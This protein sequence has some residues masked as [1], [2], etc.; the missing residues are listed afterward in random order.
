MTLYYDKR[1]NRMQITLCIIFILLLLLFAAAMVFSIFQ[2]V[3]DTLYAERSKNLNEVSEQM[4]KTIDATSTSAWDISTAAFSHMLSS[5]IDSKDDISKFLAEAENSDYNRNFYLAAV[6]SEMHYYIADGRTGVWKNSSYLAQ[7]TPENQVFMTDD[8]FV[9]EDEYMVLLH[10]LQVPLLLKDGTRITHTALICDAD[11]YTTIFSASGFDGVADVFIVH[12]DGR[13]IY[14]RDN[15]G[16]F[17]ASPNILNILKD[18]SYLKGGTYEILLE[19]LYDPAAESLE[20]TYEG[21]NYFVSLAPTQTQ[22]WNVVLIMP[23]DKLQNSTVGLLGSVTYRIIIVASIGVLLATLII[24]FFITAGNNRIL[25]QQQN[26]VSEVLRKAADEATR[27]NSAKSEFLSHMSHD[28]RTP[29]NGIM[30]M[31]EIAE[32]NQDKPDVVRKCLAKIRTASEHLYSLINDVLDMSRLESG[33]TELNE[34]IFD[35][36]EMLDACCS[37]IQG[38]LEERDIDFEYKCGQL[39]HPH[40]K[41]C[42]LYMRQILI[43]VLGNAVKFTRD[44]GRICFEVEEIV[45]DDNIARF[46]FAVSDT[47]IGMSEEYQ[48]HLFEPFSQE[49]SGSRT[50]Y[51]GTGLGMAITKKLVDKMG[52]TIDVY[53]KAN[54]GTRFTITVPF[55]ID[56]N[57]DMDARTLNSENARFPE[58]TL[59]ILAEDNDLNREIAEYILKGAGAEVISVTNGKDAVSAFSASECGSV[60]A[61]LMDVMMPVMNGLEAAK[62]IRALPRDDALSVPIVAMTANAF[63]EDVEKTQK[64][65]M[66]AH[67]SKPV[68]GKTLV[69]VLLEVIHVDIHGDFSGD[70]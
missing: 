32:Q 69:H 21:E 70:F 4:A 42:D 38:S 8:K 13:N 30:G 6:D 64:A 54:E 67:L 28:L 19:S 35:V 23:T 26:H 51:G 41:G 16:I 17:D 5:E 15:T 60:D 10:R 29:I 36:R 37:I 66:N 9:V 46:R 48:E 31:L 44:G 25:V 3:A 49:Q 27:A 24:Y 61:I 43:N 1:Q 18:V 39:A 58:G 14:K 50:N 59:I 45:S 11:T 57:A 40:I 63:A 7:T 20:F 65:G 2:S 62:N 34:N 53:S 55:S 56:E 47:G 52:G 12:D 68:N 22:D 33:K